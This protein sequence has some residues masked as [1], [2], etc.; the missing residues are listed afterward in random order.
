MMDFTSV[1]AMLDRMRENGEASVDASGLVEQVRAICQGIDYAQLRNHADRESIRASRRYSTGLNLGYLGYY[2]LSDVRIQITSNMRRGRL[3]RNPGNNS[4]YT[5]EYDKAGELLRIYEPD[6]FA[7]T[8][9]CAKKDVRC[10]VTFDSYAAR[11]TPSIKNAAFAKYD[12]EGYPEAILDIFWYHDDL[13]LSSIDIDIYEP[14][15][16]HTQKCHLLDVI[17]DSQNGTFH[18]FPLIDCATITYDDRGKILSV[19]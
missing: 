12:W 3:V 10:F 1:R 18:S 9:Y 19:D 2:T 15:C 13:T 5:Y 17:Q 4:D 6:V 11:K 8:Y 14:P 16:G 7:I